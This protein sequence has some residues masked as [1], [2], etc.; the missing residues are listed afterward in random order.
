MKI[1]GVKVV[2][3]NTNNSKE[4]GWLFI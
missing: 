2:G 1:I 3:D 4:G